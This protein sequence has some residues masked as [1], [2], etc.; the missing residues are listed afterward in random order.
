M[1]KITTCAAA[2]SAAFLLSPVLL[3]QDVAWAWVAPGSQPATFVPAQS[4]QYSSTGSTIT[5]TRDASQANR[6]T[7]RV[8]GMTAI[9]GVVHATAHGGNHTAVVN[10]WSFLS[11]ELRATIE[12]FTP[13]GGPA[14]NANFSFSYEKEG[15]PDARQ[16]HMWANNPTAASYTPATA[17]LWNGN[18]ANP[19]IT[20]ASTGVYSVL[21]PGLANNSTHRGHVQVTPWGNSLVR[22]NVAGWTNSGNDLVVTVRTHAPG[23]VLADSAFVLSYNET[24]VPID[25]NEGSGSHVFANFAT[26]E[27]YSPLATH[28]FSNGQNGPPGAETVERVGIGQYIVRLPSVVGAVSSNAQATT[29]GFSNYYATIRSW[30]NDPCGGARVRV[31]TYTNI[32]APVD[33]RFVL[34]YMTNRPAVQP[35]I[36]W[37]W[38]VPGNSTGT[39]TPSSSYQYTSNGTTITVTRNSTTPN[40]YTVRIPDI[41]PVTGGSFHACSWGGNHTTVINSW[42]RS[43]DDI[44]ATVET[45]TPS[46]VPITTGAF[47]IYYRFGGS[48]EAREAYCYANQPSAASYT[49]PATWSW[50]GDRGAPIVTRSGPG[51]YQVRFPNLGSTSGE[52]GNAQVSPHSFGMLRAKVTSWFTSGSDVLVNVATYNAAG[53]RID[54]RFVC[55]YNEVASP[56]PIGRGSGA[57]VWANNPTAATYTPN[58]TYTDSNGTLGPDNAETITRLGNGRY[59]VHLPNVA[60]SGS[61]TVQVTGH[62]SSPTFARVESWVGGSPTGTYVTVRTFNASGV[63][64]DATFSLFY[65]TDRPAVESATN[66]SIG[67]SC[68]G[69]SL[70][71][72]TRPVLC[73]DWLL[74]VGNVPANAVLGFIQLDLTNPNFTIGSQAPGCTIYTNGAV[75]VLLFL[76]IGRPA[77]RQFIPN[78]PGLIGVS[79]YAQGGAFVPGLNA[80]SLAASNGVRGT[81]GDY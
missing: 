33:T 5:V 59:R 8:P 68:N 4:W 45:F 42:I 34:R 72:A 70:A 53:N 58:A 20:R 75:T 10:S 39:F 6:F 29:Y 27:K 69:I 2:L 44:V 56:M 50:N 16:A 36:A 11:G 78:D 65:L 17:Y 74:D 71:A 35:D 40:V 79:L 14:D 55:S 1:T 77:F 32:G 67:T 15:D 64:T 66:T 23:G 21:L 3:A 19:T 49:P 28:R 12:L 30:N 7:V 60:P 80:Y 24:A 41:A 62:G 52:G 18:R 73:Q 37:A 43:G 26:A 38:C 9:G 25:P 46:G 57:H 76:P 47:N 13:L 31:E 61:S 63:S 54:G 51:T 48:S 81:I 22:A